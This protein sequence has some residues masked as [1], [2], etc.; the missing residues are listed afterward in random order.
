M[1]TVRLRIN[2]KIYDKLMWLL[3]KF[4]TD[5]L[6]I[7]TETQDFLSVQSYL[8]NTLNDIDNKNASFLSVDNL[9]EELENS[10]RK[11]EN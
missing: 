11:Y 9:N 4:K 5:E 1:Q 8:Q 10:I 7:I 6:E 3:S 2:D